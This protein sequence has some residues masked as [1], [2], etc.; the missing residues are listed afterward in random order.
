MMCGVCSPGSGARP[1]VPRDAVAPHRSAPRALLENRDREAALGELVGGGEAADPAAE[2]RDGLGPAP[3]GGFDGPPNPWVVKAPAPSA[4]AR[5]SSRR[6]IGFIGGLQRFS[7]LQEPLVLR[8]RCV[9]HSD[10][11]K[12]EM[13][14]DGYA[15]T[16]VNLTNV[17]RAY[18]SRA[19]AEIHPIVDAEFDGKGRRH[20]R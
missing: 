13:F 2:D 17:S 10:E 3:P 5:R 20:G 18:L 8:T 12:P 4:A 1:P 11:R 6:E 7:F 14:S 16:A 9:R 15:R 19:A